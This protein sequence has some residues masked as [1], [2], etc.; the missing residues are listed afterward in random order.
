M[1]QGLLPRAP[2]NAHLLSPRCRLCSDTAED[3]SRHKWGRLPVLGQHLYGRVPPRNP[4]LGLRHL[5]RPV[6]CRPYHHSAITPLS[7][8]GWSKD[9][10]LLLARR[11]PPRRHGPSG[12]WSRSTVCGRSAGRLRRRSHSV[13]RGEGLKSRPRCQGCPSRTRAALLSP[14][15]LSQG[16]RSIGVRTSAARLANGRLH[17]TA[18]GDSQRPRMRRDR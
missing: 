15:V 4:V 9:V 11:P 10:R 13:R 8:K 2:V 7:R 3:G 5:C 6:R 17:W 16:S 14:L 18:A 1:H 12:T